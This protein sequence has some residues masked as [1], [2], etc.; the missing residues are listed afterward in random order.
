MSEA[1]AIQQT[2]RHDGSVVAIAFSKDSKRLATGGGST[3]VLVRAVE[4]G[5]SVD[6]AVKG[7]VSGLAFSPDGAKLAIADL[8]QV[9]VY[10]STQNATAEEQALWKGPIK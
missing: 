7:F 1:G 9:L 10:D 6:I 8:D 3:K 4:A 2:I 5:A